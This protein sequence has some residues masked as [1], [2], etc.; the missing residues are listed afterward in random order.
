MGPREC[1]QCRNGN[2]EG[3]LPLVFASSYRESK[4][5]SPPLK[6]RKVCLQIKGFNGRTA[7]EL[8]QKGK[9]PPLQV[10]VLEEITLKSGEAP[11]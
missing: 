3:F 4:D 8:K 11:T 1:H 7:Q 6:G 10:L 5:D 9:G 2:L